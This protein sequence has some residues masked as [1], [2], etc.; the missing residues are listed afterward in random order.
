MASIAVVVPELLPVPP[1]QGGAV[2]HWVQEAFGRM[3]DEHTRVTVI[4]RP[5][6]AEGNSASP[7]THVG[8]PWTSTERWF[9]RIKERVTWRNPLRYLAKIQNVWSYGRRAGAA[10]REMN[11]DIINIQNEP[12]LM[13]FIDKR[14][15]QKLVLHMHNEHLG[16]RLLRPFY[17]RA[18]ARV[19]TVICVS[20]Y[21]RRQAVR[22]YPEH[23]HK[24]TVLLNSTEPAVFRPYGAEATEAL[25]KV[26]PLD[27]QLRYLLYVGRLTEIKGVHV[28]I[29][30]F[31]KLHA[32]RPETRLVIA[33]SSFFA[34]A[35]TTPYIESLV[36]M[37]A[38]IKDAIIFT[39]F[40][41]HHQLKYLYSAADVIVVPSV[42][43]DPCPLVVLEAMSS[44]TCLVA[45]AVG[46][47][48]ELVSDGQT[49]LLVPA[50]DAAAITAAVEGLLEQPARIE[51]VGNAARQRVLDAFTW[52]RLVADQHRIFG[53]HA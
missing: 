23:A 29:D 46:G 42:W 33:G 52:E 17:R 12:N 35:A 24:F 8:I 19:D 49:G 3:Q 40:L 36:A 41:P 39:G 14:P 47:V 21:I 25:A 26:L 2:E 15:G 31:R 44:G 5:A 53:S 48:P 6:G 51:Q 22:F 10:L 7:M 9:A 4:S 43:Q 45:T 28:L 11:V 50:D 20:D 13:F 37:A 32:R 30:A 34:G 18:L 16:I 1:V 38:P 27:P